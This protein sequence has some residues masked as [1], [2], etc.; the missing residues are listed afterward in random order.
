MKPYSSIYLI[1]F[2]PQFNCDAVP[3]FESFSKDNSCHL[4]SAL[5][6]NH[7]EVLT[8]FLNN[9]NITY[10]FDERDKEFLPVEFR[11]FQANIMF[12]DT[13]NM[14]NFLKIL[15]EKYFGKN[16][17]NLLIF[18]NSIGMRET[19]IQRA[20]N[21]LTID[22]EAVVIGRANNNKSVFIGF[23]S[24][25]HDLFTNINWNNINFDSLLA[26]VNKH[27]NFVHVLGNF[28]YID[29]IDDFRNLYSELSKKESLSYCS[30]IMHEKFT[31]LFIEYKD[32][33]K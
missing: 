31:N 10:C 23:N 15:S 17:K 19:D 8:S 25:N 14:S 22:D 6:L 11:N 20:L 2:S 26:K 30:P 4:Y 16:N 29:K 32:L 28:M 3:L 7:K 33:L 27:E 1:A 9:N 12:F 21:L 24:F 13:L 5:T 18:S